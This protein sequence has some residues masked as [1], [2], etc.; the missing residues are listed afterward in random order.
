M[1][2]K[3][4]GKLLQDQPLMTNVLADLCLEAEASTIMSMKMSQLFNYSIIRNFEPALSKAI[5]EEEDI[6]MENAR[7]LFRIGVAVSKY[8]ITKRMPQYMYECMEAHGGNGF[9]EDFPMARMYRHAPLNAIWEGS[10][11]VIAMDVLRA[12]AHIRIFMKEVLTC[13]GM[14]HEVDEYIKALNIYI[15]KLFKLYHDP[16][17]NVF[18]PEMQ[19]RA[20]QIV[21]HMAIAMQ[22]SLLLRYGCPITADLFIQ[23]RIRS[24]NNN[25]NNSFMN[26]INYGGTPFDIIS[27]KRIIESNMPIVM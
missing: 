9:V 22:A 16:H 26:G 25:T 21:D 4:F 11:N 14:S 19:L 6:A 10:G 13:R 27:A 23:S 2:R 7:D 1:N 8:Y 15:D 17:T 5:M 3:A 20:R 12:S 24:T 18:S